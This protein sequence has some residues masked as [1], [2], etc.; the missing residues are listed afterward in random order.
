[1]KKDLDPNLRDVKA[2]KAT[3]RSVEAA[4][5]NSLVDGT[6]ST[7]HHRI[8]RDLQERESSASAEKVKNTFLGI[9]D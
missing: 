2:G 7:I 5:I 8:Y 1:M 4:D 3:G 9:F 6:K